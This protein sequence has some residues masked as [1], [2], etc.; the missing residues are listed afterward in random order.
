MLE[1]LRV[2]CAW[3]PYSVSRS[4]SCLGGGVNLYYWDGTKGSAC[5]GGSSSIGVG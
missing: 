3:R 1:L 2:P 4:E 5:D